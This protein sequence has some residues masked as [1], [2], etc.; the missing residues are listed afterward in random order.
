[1][2]KSELTAALALGNLRSDRCPSE[3]ERYRGEPRGDGAR[4]GR[5]RSRGG[6]PAGGALPAVDFVLGV[7]ADPQLHQPLNLLRVPQRR[8]L[9]QPLL[10]LP[11]S[12]R[13]RHLAAAPGG[14]QAGPISHLPGTHRPRGTSGG[15][16]VELAAQQCHPRRG[17][18]WGTLLAVTPPAVASGSGSELGPGAAAPVT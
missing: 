14:L 3:G 7:G 5:E 17:P 15:G 12:A 16:S 9:P 1:M 8:R 6:D 18:G 10:P 2:R 11:L 4:P 13:S